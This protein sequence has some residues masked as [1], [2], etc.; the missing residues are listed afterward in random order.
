MANENLSSEIWWLRR[1]FDLHHSS[2]QLCDQY[3]G[4]VPRTPLLGVV[5]WYRNEVCVRHIHV[6][7]TLVGEHESQIQDARVSNPFTRDK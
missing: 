1:A 3:L 6:L 5:Q 2:I 7:D 4:L